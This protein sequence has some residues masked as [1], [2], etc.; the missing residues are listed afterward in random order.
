[1]KYQLHL[2]TSVSSN[3]QVGGMPVV[4]KLNGNPFLTSI[5]LGN[6]HRNVETVELKSLEMPIGFYNIR[7]PYNTFV[8][9]GTTYTVP[10]G[11]YTITTLLAAM[12]TAAGSAPSFSVSGSQ[13]VA[14]YSIVTANLIVNLDYPINNSTWTNLGS[15][16][17]TYNATAVGTPTFVAG[18]TPSSNYISFNGTSQYYS[19]P[20][21]VND[22]FSIGVWFKTTTN[23]GSGTGAWYVSPSIIGGDA[24]GPGRDYGLS[25]GTGNINFGTGPS[26]VTVHSVNKYNNGNWHYVVVTRTRSNGLM[27]IYVDGVLDVLNGPIYSNPNTSLDS[28]PLNYI[29]YDPAGAAFFNGS[30]AAVQYYTAVLTPEQIIG[31]YNVQKYRFI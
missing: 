11:N 12:T 2:D 26:D 3:V 19:I 27:N 4:S 28:Q 1:M 9:N 20:R 24:G 22:D 25:I 6:K 13:V 8:V 21:P 31:N 5:L 23:A 15:G 7:S 17:S 10:P 14:I 29:A 16:G 18:T 30:V